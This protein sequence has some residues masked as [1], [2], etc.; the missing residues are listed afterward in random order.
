VHGRAVPYIACR[1]WSALW[2]AS[3]SIQ[4]ATHAQDKEA[5][6]NVVAQTSLHAPQSSGK[7][8][9]SVFVQ[10][11]ELSVQQMVG[12]HGYHNEVA[13]PNQQPP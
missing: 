4:E 9:Q 7:K 8:L 2:V 11:N 13:E 12:I 6:I 5:D 3:V 10:L 1:Y